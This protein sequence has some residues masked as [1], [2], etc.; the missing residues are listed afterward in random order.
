MT[1]AC[2]AGCGTPVP[3]V[4]V[5][6]EPVAA[7]CDACVA[8]DRARDRADRIAALLARA[9]PPPRMRGWSLATHPTQNPAVYRWLEGYI[10]GTRESLILT[11]SIGVGKTGFAWGLARALCE[12][13]IPAMFVNFRD[14]LHGRRLGFDTDGGGDMRPHTVPVLALD[15]LGSERPT[16]WARDEL[17]TL[18]EHRT[19]GNRPTIV[20]TNYTADNLAQRL[21]HDDLLL[22][23]RI[24]SRL[25]Q[26][27]VV[28]EIG[29]A[30]RR[31]H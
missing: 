21:G 15:D 19:G 7:C 6:G 23:Q 14:Y 28:I 22:G 13:E 31:A 2:A 10:A 16:D 12:H 27:A 9:C 20:T 4:E 26:D 5:L 29:G 1:A 30:D 3:V 17:A 18:V 8:G 25:Y 11:G 24:V